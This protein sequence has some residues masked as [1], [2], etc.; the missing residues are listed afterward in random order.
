MT[1]GNPIFNSG[2]LPLGASAPAGKCAAVFPVDGSTKSR[3]KYHPLSI[4]NERFR[5]VIQ[6][7]IAKW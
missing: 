5:E 2:A 4:E 7:G 1:G 3:V 6:G